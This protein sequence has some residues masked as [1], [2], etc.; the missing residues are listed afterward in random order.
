MNRGIVW[1]GSEY[2]VAYTDNID[3][4]NYP[5]P[6]NARLQRLAIDGTKIGEAI[7][8]NEPYYHSIQSFGS[9]IWTGSEIG[10]IY[11]QNEEPWRAYFTRLAPDGSR[12][13]DPVLIA[14]EWCGLAC[15]DYMH[16]RTSY[17]WTGKAYGVVL[18]DDTNDLRIEKFALMTPKGKM[19]VL[20][21]T[22]LAF[23]AYSLT[24]SGSRF[25]V[26]DWQ[27]EVD[28]GYWEDSYLH[29]V[30]LDQDG[31]GLD[32]HEEAGY[33]TDMYDWDT[34]D[35]GMRDGWEVGHYCLDPL[36]ADSASDPDGDGQ[37]NIEEYVADTEPCDTTD[38]DGDGLA[39]LAETGIYGT[40]P[41]LYDTDGDGLSDGDEVLN[42]STDPL[43][44]DTDGDHMPD[45]FE[46]ANASGH[47]PGELLDAI[48]PADG[49]LDFD[50]DDIQNAHEY[51]NKTDPWSADPVPGP[52]YE[53]GCYYWGDG[54]GDGVVGP[55]D[56]AILQLEIAG[57]TQGFGNVIPQYT[58]DTLDLDKDGGPGPGDKALLDAMLVGTE[59]LTGYPSSPTSLTLAD[60]PFTT[61][62]VG[63]TTHITVGVD[64]ASS[65]V[66]NSGGFAVVFAVDGDSST[67]A[68]TLLGGEGTDLAGAGGNR[69]DMSGASASGGLANIVVRVESAGT[70]VIRV[71]IP[72]CGTYP[73]GRWCDY[74]ELIP[75]ITITGQ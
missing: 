10:L 32:D 56:V 59:R 55:G 8:L 47:D 24:W 68:A 2:F 16:I 64:N 15:S 23:D 46:V 57:D 75:A 18:G 41:G 70:I 22:S 40:D 21:D 14:E 72:G 54:D 30:Y 65:G 74:I 44:W 4:N 13:D 51:W 49:P 61:V 39:D 11:Q 37:S 53:P 12:L 63:E 66:I 42:Y 20:D 60:S 17:T 3:I 19:L 69:Y 67:G 50:N 25:G 27:M 33:A 48:N 7:T 38:S 71:A 28:G 73:N 43:S 9:L 35:D 1:T 52:F 45:A 26:V 34:D 36:A 58:F 31:D 62:S 29:L 5:Y 6:G